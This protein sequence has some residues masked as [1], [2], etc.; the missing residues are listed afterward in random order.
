MY[1]MLIV[2]DE[3]LVLR[4]IKETIDWASYNIEIIGEASNGLDGFNMALKLKPDIIISDIKMPLLNGVGLAEKL[5]Q[6]SF[7][8]ALIILSGYSDFEYARKAFEN[9]I[10]AYLL[11]PIDNQELIDTVVN[12]LHKLL[13]RRRKTQLLADVEERMPLLRAEVFKE[14]FEGD[15]D[16]SDQITEKLELH[17]IKIIEQGYVLYG[18]LDEKDDNFE[19]L[20]SLYQLIIDHFNN[21]KIPNSAELYRDYFVIIVDVDKVDIIKYHLTEVMNTFEQS[22]NDLFSIGVS[23]YF[24][25]LSNIKDN[26]LLAK[27]VASNKIFTAI[28]TI[29]FSNEKVNNY[30]IKIQNALDIIYRKYDTG[31]T[32]SIVA[33]DLNVSESYLMHLFKDTL[34]MTFNECLTNYR[35]MIAK[36]LLLKGTYRINEIAHMVGYGDVKYFGQVFRRIVGMTPS[37][38][39]NNHNLIGE[40]NA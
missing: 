30:N 31:L 14:L 35:I 3:Y 7:D 11:K 33:E 23:E 18:H 40:Y 29:T 1:K 24:T 21:R 15:F 4:G 13:E 6:I 19:V 27:K 32:V 9:G 5:N 16:N 22:Y 34:G 12:S 37:D 10:F 38:F 28:N 8:C 36:K 26:Y 2:D 39:I 20:K 25:N 17:N